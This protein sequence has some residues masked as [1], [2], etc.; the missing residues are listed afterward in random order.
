MVVVGAS[1]VDI[2]SSFVITKRISMHLTV[3]VTATSPSLVLPAVDGRRSE[4]RAYSRGS[5]SRRSWK[6]RLSGSHLGGN[7]HLS[8]SRRLNGSRQDRSRSR[9]FRGNGSRRGGR[10][11][12]R[13]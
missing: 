6:R 3:V 5:G 13:C 9:R 7:S 4:C 8:G 11:L 1:L 10:V 2:S 12:S